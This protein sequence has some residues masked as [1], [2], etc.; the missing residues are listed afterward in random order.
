MMRH[1]GV[2][3]FSVVV[4]ITVAV[5]MARAAFSAESRYTPVVMWHGMGDSCCLPFSLGS[6]TKLLQKQLPGVHVNSL[7]IGDNVVSDTV[8]GFFGRVDDQV[9]L[10]CKLIA[11]DEILRD[12]YNAIGFSQGGQFLRAVA[13]RC[14]SPP[15]RS[16]ITL[17]GQHQ[18]VFGVPHCYAT[19]TICDE[20]RHL[21]DYG[22]YTS[23]VQKLSVQA[24]YWKD[25]TDLSS[26]REYSAFLADINNERDVK[27][28]SYKENLNRLERF[29]MVRFSRDSMV[30][31]RISSHFGY[32]A[33]GQ[34]QR[35]QNLTETPIYLQDWLGL[36]Q[37]HDDGKLV[38]LTADGDHLQIDGDWF[39]KY[40]VN[41]FLN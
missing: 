4:F 11:E 15:M 17:G 26:Y 36:R 13:Q 32:Y 2:L 3:A 38:F 33:P 24:Q 25:P 5:R 10:A 16:L 7:R 8:N 9:E 31:P 39:I 1:L 28:E 20:M 12:G 18:G 23:E 22:A 21:L 30:I 34:D 29:V 14:P 40:I 27:N 19:S 37:M 35:V 6:V 41:P